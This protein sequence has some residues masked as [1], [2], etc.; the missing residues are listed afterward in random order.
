MLENDLKLSLISDLEEK[1]ILSSHENKIFEC[2]F[3]NNYCKKL[4]DVNFTI[5][6]KNYNLLIELKEKKET[7]NINL[8]DII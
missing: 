7:F 2:E 3:F 6:Y 8:N 5:N 1:I 4:F